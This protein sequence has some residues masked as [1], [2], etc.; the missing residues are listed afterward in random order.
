[1]LLRLESFKETDSIVS[2][3][4]ISHH[5]GVEYLDVE[6]ASTSDMSVNFLQ[7]TRRNNPEDSHLQGNVF[8]TD[9]KSVE[10]RGQCVSPCYSPRAKN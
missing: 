5:Q 3:L 6:A 8:E 2:M 10:V 9:I 7:T 4:S 1:M